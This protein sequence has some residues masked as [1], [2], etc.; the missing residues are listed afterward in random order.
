LLVYLLI[1]CRNFI[2]MLF[3]P[4]KYK[5]ITKPKKLIYRYFGEVLNERWAVMFSNLPLAFFHT[6]QKAKHDFSSYLEFKRF[7]KKIKPEIKSLISK[8]NRVNTEDKFSLDFEKPEIIRDENKKD[9]WL[10]NMKVQMTVSKDKSVPKI[11]LNIK[12]RLIETD[13]NYLVDSSYFY[14]LIGSR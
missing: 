6:T 4:L 13:G 7:C 1:F 2:E 11:P 9:F 3:V 10:F 8:Y 12:G 5:G 14:L